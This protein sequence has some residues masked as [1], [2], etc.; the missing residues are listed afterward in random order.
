MKNLL[1]LLS[2]R[3]VWAGIFGFIGFILPMLGVT[4]SLEIDS[5]SDAMTNFV[6]AFSA[7][8]TAILPIISYFKPKK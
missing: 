7:L 3:R 5:L 1:E 6:V 8:M 2:Q 4:Y